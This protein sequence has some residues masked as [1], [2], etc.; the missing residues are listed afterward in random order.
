MTNEQFARQEKMTVSKL[1]DIIDSFRD[2]TTIN[3]LIVNYKIGYLKV[4]RI[5]AFHIWQSQD[6]RPMVD[7]SKQYYQTEDEMLIQDY[8]AEDLTGEEKLILDRL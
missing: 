8:K 5:I 6:R 1:R 2:G 4:K 7:M 3:T